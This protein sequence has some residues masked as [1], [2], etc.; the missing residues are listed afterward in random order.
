M[1][2]AGS[3][4]IISRRVYDPNDRRTCR[5]WLAANP[6]DYS[7]HPLYGQIDVVLLKRTIE[8]TTGK[9]WIITFAKFWCDCH[10][11]G[12]PIAALDVDWDGLTDMRDF[13]ILAAQ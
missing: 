10:P 4:F 2:P 9:P 8:Q 6:P 13:A 11:P 3:L 1:P 12:D 7:G 5:Q